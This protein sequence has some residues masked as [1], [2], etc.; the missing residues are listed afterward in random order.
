MT[1]KN[2]WMQIKVRTNNNY[3][4]TVASLLEQLGALSVTFEDAEDS[5]IL[6]P[7]PGE[8][9]LWPS[10][11]V[12]GLFAQG[13]DPAPILRALRAILGDHIPM[14]AVGLE[15][16]NWIREWM[17][18]F[19]PIKCGNRLWICP[20]WLHVDEKDAVTV[21]LDPGLA[22]G[23]GTHPTTWLCLNFLDSLDLK[24]KTVVD[25]GCGSGILGIAALKLGALKASGVDI[26]DQAII[27]SDENAERNGVKGLFTLYL[28]E[29][30]ADV[31][32]AD[33]TVANILAGPLAELEPEIARLTAKGGALALSGVLVEQAQA[34]KDAY[35]KDFTMGEIKTRGDWALLTGIRR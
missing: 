8:R 24:G 17:S 12:S 26:D 7:R 3:S 27:A 20:S 6:E 32:P 28:N 33:V 13:T 11:E 29:A 1:E 25:Y 10:T 31:T 34:V 19:K 30:A 14:A 18:Q 4:D 5:P 16:R 2:E 35:A 9:R 21:M 23:T 22:F 15:D